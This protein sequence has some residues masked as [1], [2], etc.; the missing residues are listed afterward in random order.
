MAAMLKTSPRAGVR[1][2]GENVLRVPL[3]IWEEFAQALLLSNE[4]IYVN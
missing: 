2:A 1:N 4:A 3:T